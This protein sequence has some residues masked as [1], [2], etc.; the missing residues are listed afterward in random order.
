MTQLWPIALIGILALAAAGYGVYVLMP[1]LLKPRWAYLFGI[2]LA[3]E[4][5]LF[6][7]APFLGW[8][9]PRGVSTYSGAVDALFY[10]ILA[11]T[12]VTFVLVSFVFVFVLYRYTYDPNRKSVYTHGSHKLEMI[13]TAIPAGIL[14]ILS[15]VQIPAWLKV[16][17]TDW[18]KQAFAKGQ[19]ED[20]KRFLQFEVA[21]RQWEWRVR[22]PSSK[23]YD[24]WKEPKSALTDVRTRMQERP[25]DLRFANEIHCFKGQKVLI[26]LKTHDVIHSL[27]LPQMRLKQDALPG[28]TIPVWFEATEANCYKV[29]DTWQTG[30]RFDSAANEWMKDKKYLW[31]FACAEF[32]GARHSLMRG[33]VYVHETEDDFLDWLRS[34][35]KAQAAMTP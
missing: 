25:D 13:W 26:H 6:L 35:E 15:V 7:V 8:W 4:F 18:L 22:Y 23:R 30:F 3:L 34:A 10:G 20:G 33:K 17:N 21:A 32:C 9:L 28:K 24:E 31:E 12:G 1:Q 2:I 14:L 19:T 11:V 27:Y 5:A 29:G 16:K